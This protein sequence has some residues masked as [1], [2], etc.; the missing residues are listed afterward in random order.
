MPLSLRCMAH[1][2]VFWKLHEQGEKG[3]ARRGELGS[4][5]SQGGGRFAAR[6]GECARARISKRESNREGTR[7]GGGGVEATSQLPLTA[8]A[9]GLAGSAARPWRVCACARARWRG[10]VLLS[11]RTSLSRVPARAFS[12]ACRGKGPAE[13][14]KVRRHLPVTARV[15]G[16]C[17]RQAV[18]KRCRPLILCQPQHL[19][20]LHVISLWG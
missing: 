2:H 1:E 6:L 16:H 20:A 15:L 13:A 7:G 18:Q 10:C 14:E 5:R 4:V 9:R 3:E 8:R 12:L 17:E 19:C 11:P